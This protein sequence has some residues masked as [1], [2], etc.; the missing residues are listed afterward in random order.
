MMGIHRGPLW[1]GWELGQ[2]SED[3]RGGTESAV[4]LQVGAWRWSLPSPWWQWPWANRGSSPAA[5]PVRTAG[6]PWCSGGAWTPAWAPCSQAPAA[7]SSPCTTPHCRPRGSTHV[8]AP[9][10]PT[11]SGTTCGSWCSVSPRP[12]SQPCFICFYAT[13]AREPSQIAHPAPA[14]TEMQPT[15]FSPHAPPPPRL[16]AF[17]PTTPTHPQ[18]SHT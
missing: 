12:S 1:R 6:P 14:Q 13:S 11:L 7:A 2:G 3:G 10:G 18:T 17:T 9:A 8:W 15:S 4:C 5:G 16:P